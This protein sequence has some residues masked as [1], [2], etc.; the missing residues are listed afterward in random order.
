M[1]LITD[2]ERN[3]PYDDNKGADVKESSYR[4]KIILLSEDEGSTEPK[5]RIS[6]T[7]NQHDVNRK[8]WIHAYIYSM[9]KPQTRQKI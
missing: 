6:T 5:I 4:T 2:N 9:K 8:K 1:R 3:I 7:N